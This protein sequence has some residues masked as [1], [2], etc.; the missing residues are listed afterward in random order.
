MILRYCAGEFVSHNMSWSMW[1]HDMRTY[2]RNVAYACATLTFVAVKRVASA[3]NFIIRAVCI[4]HRADAS[5]YSAAAWGA[6]C[7]PSVITIYCAKHTVT[8]RWNIFA[9]LLF[10]SSYLTI[11]THCSSSDKP[12]GLT[13]Q[14]VLELASLKVPLI[15]Q[16]YTKRM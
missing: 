13:S 16:A 6:T 14:C 4:H 15:T 7:R 11:K 9:E 8:T 12:P 1:M 2:A 3:V 10:L 5:A